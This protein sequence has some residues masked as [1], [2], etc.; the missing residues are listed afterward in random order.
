M[1]DWHPQR[2]VRSVHATPLRK[3]VQPICHCKLDQG[4][5]L[6]PQ[7]NEMPADVTSLQTG[8]EGPPSGSSTK[9]GSGILRHDPP[10]NGTPDRIS[11]VF[12]SRGS[13]LKASDSFRRYCVALLLSGLI[14]PGTVSAFESDVHFG[15]TQWL[16]LQAGF[17]PR[18]AEAL[19]IGDQRVDSGD[20]QFMD[21][22]TA[23]GCLRK[24]AESSANVERR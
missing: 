1:R 6:R 14:V 5:M 19:A 10:S 21:L 24:S 20:M 16:A 17:V 2:C 8:R 11:Q 22:V 23:Y 13:R 3:L 12:I 7:T 18:E 4:R 9:T 15:L